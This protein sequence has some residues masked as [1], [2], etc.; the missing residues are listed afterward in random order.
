MLYKLSKPSPKVQLTAAAILK[1]ANLTES[2]SEAR[3]AVAIFNYVRDT[4]Q[5]GFTGRFDYATPDETLASKRGHCN[6]QGALFASLCQAVGLSARQHFVTIDNHVL[7]G[8]LDGFMPP[9]LLHSYVEVDIDG[10]TR[11]VDGYIA[12]KDLFE[13]ARKRLEKE[14]KRYGYG[15]AVDGSIQFDGYSDCFVQMTAPPLEDFGAF[16]SPSLMYNSPKNFQNIPIFARVFFGLGT[17]LF[18]RRIDE[19]IT[20]YL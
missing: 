20:M 1:E 3:K 10:I 15:V 14:G 13:A 7:E 16:D 17:I 2:S 9:K 8:V 11:S 4:I 12:Q 6:P 5:F 19:T 18:N